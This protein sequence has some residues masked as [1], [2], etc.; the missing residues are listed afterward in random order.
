MTTRPARTPARPAP[1]PAEPLPPPGFGSR[2]LGWSVMT[3]TLGLVSC[4]SL[5]LP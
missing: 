3:L 1:L 4:Q 5:F 2:A